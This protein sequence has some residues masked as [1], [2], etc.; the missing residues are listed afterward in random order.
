MYTS[1]SEHIEENLSF[2]KECKL[3]VAISG[4]LD[5]V[6]LT[7]LA[8]AYGLNISL[9]HCNFN[10][11]GTE[12][13]ND[14]VFVKKMAETIDV[15]CFVKHFDTNS[16]AEQKKV[17]IQMAART[18]RYHWFET[19]Q[20]EHHFDYVLTAHHLDDSV[21][22]FLINLLRGSGLDGFTGIPEVNKRVVRPLL[23]FS[24]EEILAYAE[25]HQL[26]WRE[27][28]SNASTK[29]LRNALRKDVI[30]KLK[31]L[32]PQFLDNFKTSQEHLKAAKHILSDS[33][34]KF[35][36]ETFS[37]QNE[38]TKIKISTILENNNPKAYLYY[39]L[40]DYGF[41]AWDDV[42]D[43][44]KAQSGKQLFSEGYRLVKDRDYI[45]LVR[46]QK[47]NDQNKTFLIQDEKTSI[48]GPIRLQFETVETI[49]EKNKNILYV[50]REMLKFPLKIRKWENGDYFYPYGMK[51]KKKLSKFFKDEKYSIIDKENQWLLCAEDKILWVIGKRS[52]NRF[53]LTKQSKHFIKITLL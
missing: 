2:L 20:K 10:L 44:L 41:T 18:L 4:G 40:K 29:Y 28:S 33:I 35:K 25:E 22:T 49:T 13:D 43:L 26:A 42:L 37:F 36:S 21:E 24:R 31:A 48:D 50:D 1:F 34:K 8:H 14:E 46:K 51:N 27:D 11:R 30:P 12:S 38:V 23:A 19:L 16:Y 53:R 9:A 17:S 3:L 39:L 15:E 7:H 52:D 6:V 47:N 45:L 5:S 32:N